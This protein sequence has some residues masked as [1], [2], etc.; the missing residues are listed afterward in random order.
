MLDAKG[1]SLIELLIVVS[2]IAIITGIA[3]PSWRDYIQAARRIDATGALL[4]IAARQEQ[5]R[6]QDQRY[7]NTE[8]LGTTGNTSDGHYEM[9]VV[10]T[11]AGFEAT[12]T[13]DLNGKQHDDTECWSFGID[14]TGRRWSRSTDGTD[15]TTKCWRS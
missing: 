6:L 12:A 9:R 1:F 7:A 3:M 11:T 8:T 15:T 13:V 10:V 2:I 4:H 14:E 5:F